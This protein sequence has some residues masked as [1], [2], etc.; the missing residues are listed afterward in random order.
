MGRRPRR[1]RHP[2]GLQQPDLQRSRSSWRWTTPG[3]TASSSWLPSATTRSG[4]NSYPA[5][6][7]GVVGVSATTASDTLAGFSNY[8][9]ERLHR[10]AR[11]RHHRVRRPAAASASIS[12]TSAAAAHVAA[13]AA[14][15]R[16]NDPGVS[17]GV[18][19]AR[20]ARNAEDVGT[21]DQT[22]NGRLNIVRA[23]STPTATASSPPAPPA[24]ARSS[25]RTSPR[26]TTT[27]TSPRDG[28]RRTL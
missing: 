25:V 6:T 27:R 9:A 24:A 22:G 19:V 4:A 5:G 1:R 28:H 10:R 26:P 23:M 2:H 14:L 17:N 7:T 13:A 18:I 15:I 21:A 11:R 8:G 3:T 16:A 12:G 20:L